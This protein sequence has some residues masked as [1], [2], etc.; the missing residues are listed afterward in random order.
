MRSL[1]SHNKHQEVLCHSFIVVNDWISQPD[2]ILKDHINCNDFSEWSGL[3]PMVHI[4][5]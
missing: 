4:K 2:E 5:L 1:P 3:W